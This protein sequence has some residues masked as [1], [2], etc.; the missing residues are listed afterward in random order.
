MPYGL[1]VQPTWGHYP[2]V[3][4]LDGYAGP[5]SALNPI[6]DGGVGWSGR[7]GGV[8]VDGTHYPKRM[9]C[10]NARGRQLPDFDQQLDL[11]VSERA[12]QAIEQMEPGIHQFFPVEYLDTNGTL[13][14]TRYWLVVGNR[15][16]GMDRNHTNMIL[17][18]G[19]VWRPAKDFVRRGEAIPA[20][21]D[22][23][24]PAKLA[25]NLQAI[26]SAHL[27]VDKHLDGP[28][29]WL[30]DAMAEHFAAADLT[31]LELAASKIE[32]V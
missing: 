4:P 27:W 26:G 23:K 20:H 12:Q 30:S 28:A 32:G 18:D 13:L 14:E 9:Q 22:P 5:I 21:I 7:T 15:I 8:P 1:N 31:G 25:F 24:Q 6:N 10:A 16:D 19:N 29:I 17:E 11:N 2:K 3:E